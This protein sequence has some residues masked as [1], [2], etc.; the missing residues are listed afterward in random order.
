MT[1]EMRILLKYEHGTGMCACARAAT[2][3]AIV[4]HHLQH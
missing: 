1:R 3:D 4:V 2:W